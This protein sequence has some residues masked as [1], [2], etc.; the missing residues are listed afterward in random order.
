[1]RG[2]VCFIFIAGVEGSGTTVLSRLLG[3]PA[4]CASLGGLYVKVPKH[5]DAERLVNEFQAANS[6]AWDRRLSFTENR[7]GRRKWRAAWEHQAIKREFLSPM[8]DDRFRRELSA[9]QIAW[10][11]EFFDAR[12]S[13]Q[14]QFLK[15][16]AGE[17]DMASC[18]A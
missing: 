7:E 4:T 5:P 11:D 9:D 1:M 13:R 6:L 16:A 12:R 3:A 10:L 17:Q 8:V 18:S 2:D 15:G 14:W